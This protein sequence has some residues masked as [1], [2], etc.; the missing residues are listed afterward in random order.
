[1]GRT[2]AH[3]GR[4]MTPLVSERFSTK[5]ERS[6]HTEH[7]TVSHGSFG[8]HDEQ[9]SLNDLDACRLEVAS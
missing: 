8:Y 9:T 2:G 1:M 3:T 4:W 6:C 5:E 7:R